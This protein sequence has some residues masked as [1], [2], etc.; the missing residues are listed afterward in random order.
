[1]TPKINFRILDF[2][3]LASDNLKLENKRGTMITLGDLLE[4][5]VRKQPH[6]RAITC[7][8]E[9]V[10]L[11]YLELEQRVNSLVAAMIAMGMKRGD[12]VA[13]LSHNCHRYAE[14]FM[15]LTKGGWVLVPLDHR[16]TV[17][18]I[19]YLIENAGPR[20]IVAHPEYQEMVKELQKSRGGVETVL[21]L[22]QGPAG[23]VNYEDLIEKYLGERAEPTVEENDLLTLYYTSGTT[24]RPKGVQYT[25]RN[26]FFAMINMVIDFKISE[27]DITLNTS[28]FSHIAPIWPML[29]HFY[30]GGSN[31]VIRRFDPGLVLRTI[32]R[33]KIT[34]WNSVPVMIL[35]LLEHPDIGLYDLSSLRC[36]SYGAAPMP[37]EILKKAIHFFGPVLYQV[38]GL[39]ETYLLTTLSNKDHM[40]DESDPRSRRL[41][42]CGRE[43]INTRV[44]LVNADG[45]EIRPGEIGE[46]IAQGE[47]VTSGYW[48][49]PEETQRA[50]RNGWFYTGDLATVDEDGY[51]YIRDRKKD[52]I[53]TGGENVSPREIEEVLYSHPNVLECAVIGTPDEKWGEAVKAFVVL[54]GAK[55]ISPAELIEFCRQ[56]LAGFKTPKSI[57]FLS[58][59]PRTAS[60]KILK[61]E[62]R[63]KKWKGG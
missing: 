63:E 38:Y 35:R 40:V 1:M 52:V 7:A 31:V 56:R 16:L 27:D 57:E 46:I 11:S 45:G 36:L 2:F 13:M 54:K 30:V 15:A 33:E 23:G 19:L 43:L 9:G 55:E 62:L 61:R 28:P 3:F 44:R 25:H 8:E 34:T 51:I 47:S 24:G 22:E 12:R 32:E 59:L 60:G 18:E 29:A 49:M 6:K 53:I 26:L 41:A 14:L 48:K 58:F 20:L 5:N 17:R 10:T 21:W 37:L 42:S 4:R 50:V 39:T